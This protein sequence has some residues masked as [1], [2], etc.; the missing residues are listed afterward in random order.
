MKRFL[1]ALGVTLATSFFISTA[2]PVATHADVRLPKA[3][4]DHMVVQQKTPARIWGWADAGEKVAV[5]FAGNQATAVAGEDGAWQTTIKPPAAGGPY[6]LVIE[7]KNR[8]ELKD[9]LVGEVWI[10]SGQSNMAWTVARSDNPQK[11]IAAASHP[12]IRLLTVNRKTA[13]TP[14]ADLLSASDWELCSP[15]TVKDFSAAG[16]FF[17]RKLQQELNV[18]VGLVNTSW[19]GTRAEAWTS[20]SMLKSKP[21]LAPLLSTWK[22]RT[23]AYDAATAKTRYEA[24][25]KRWQVAANKAK[26][27]GKRVPRRPQLQGP[28]ADDRHHPANLYNAMI[29]P[30]TP[31]SIRGAIWYQGEANVGRADQY[32]PLFASM[33]QDWRN[34]WKQGDFPFLFAQLAPFRY[35]NHHPEFEAELW[36]SQFKTLSLPATGMAVITDIGNIKNIHPTNKQEVGRRLALWALGTTYGKELVYSGPLYKSMEVEGGK[37]RLSFSH[38][39][40]GLVAKDGKLTHFTI[41][42]ADKKFVPAA[43]EI[44]G[45]QV[46]VSSD[47]VK[48]P[49]AVRFGW[50]DTAEPNFFN[51]AGL[52]ASPFRTDSFKLRTAGNV[53]P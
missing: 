38:T 12:Q 48:Q 26:A 33:I 30:L 8:I 40:G 39:G 16:Y 42:G 4:G 34:Q 27:A 45:G 5:V 19:G 21:V 22:S 18:P 25:L 32:R 37:V 11:E 10:C 50:T 3:L 23:E 36:D 14:Q 9:V 47:K 6:T 52:P 53:A 2:F 17:G 13:R 35:G 49:V 24:A 43:A 20:T 51:K 46:V 15:E 1:A 44:D 28:P 29:H 41:A 31:M 7:G